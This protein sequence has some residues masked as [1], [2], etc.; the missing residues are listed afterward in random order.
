MVIAVNG[1][2]MCEGTVSDHGHV[3]QLAMGE[4]VRFKYRLCDSCGALQAASVKKQARTFNDTLLERLLLLWD[5]LSDDGI[6]A[7]PRLH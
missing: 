6:A 3:Y 4:R 2:A 1:C 5:H 7:V